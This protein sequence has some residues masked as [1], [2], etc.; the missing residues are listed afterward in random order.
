MSA[1]TLCPNCGA[2]V[3][4]DEVVCSI[5]GASLLIDMEEG[6]I[7]DVPSDEEFFGEETTSE[8]AED[9]SE[10]EA[11][12]PDEAIGSDEPIMPTSADLTEEFELS[13]DD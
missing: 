6:Q 13:E 11:M 3:D 5:C 10:K 4:E 8:S 7:E 1:R 9:I 12:G 2:E